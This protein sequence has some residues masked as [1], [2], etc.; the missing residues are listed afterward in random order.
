MFSSGGIGDLAPREC[1]VQTVAANE[2]VEDRAKIFE[3]NYPEAEVV[4][5]GIW[6]CKDEI[7]QMLFQPLSVA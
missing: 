4:V 7:V 6:T 2:V 1:G 5:G 3:R